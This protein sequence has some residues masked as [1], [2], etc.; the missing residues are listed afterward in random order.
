MADRPRRVF[1]SHT[2]ELRRLPAGRSFVAAAEQAVTRAGDAIG[3][4]AYFTARDHPPALVCRE[5]VQAADVYVAVI[6]FR[7]GSSVADQ[8]ELSYTE[9]EFQAVGEAG[10]PRL[11]FLLGAHTQ[12][13]SGLFVDED[14]GARQQAFRARLA[15]SGLTTATVTTPEGLSEVLFQALTQL[16]RPRWRGSRPG[17]C[18]TCP[19]ATLASPAATSCSPGCAPRCRPAGRRWCRPCTGWAGSTRPPW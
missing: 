4:M 12:G 5:A 17:G 19:S 1:L 18:G 9:L 16:P 3:D 13:A 11:V 7:Y 10:L 6:G 15:E 8:P 14:Y 2:S